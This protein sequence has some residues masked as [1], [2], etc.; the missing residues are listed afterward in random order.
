[1]GDSGA[2]RMATIISRNMT[3]SLI[4]RIPGTMILNP[5]GRNNFSLIGR[6]LAPWLGRMFLNFSQT[7][8]F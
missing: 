7:G 8:A 4:K 1:M 6:F 2:N 5:T 3:T